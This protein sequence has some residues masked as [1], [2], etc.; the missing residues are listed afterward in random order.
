MKGAIDWLI[1][2]SVLLLA[3][4]AITG[5]AAVAA[6]AGVALIS[7]SLNRVFSGAKND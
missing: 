6:W 7:F 3:V 4:A 1:T 5:D 2:V